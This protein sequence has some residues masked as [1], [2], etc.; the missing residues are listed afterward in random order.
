MEG[1]LLTGRNG[2]FHTYE[3]FAHVIS[4]MYNQHRKW[5]EHCEEI[6]A[7]PDRALELPDLLHGLAAGPQR[8]HPPGSRLHGPGRQQERIDH[9]GLSAR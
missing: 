4:S 6:L 3:A 9:P 1:Y 5:L 7:R 8:L 2:F